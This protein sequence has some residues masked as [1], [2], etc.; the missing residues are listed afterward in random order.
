MKLNEIVSAKEHRI[1]ELLIQYGIVLASWDHETGEIL[2]PKGFTFHNSSHVKDIEILPDGTVN[3]DGYINL[4]GTK[5][6]KLPFKFGKISQGLTIA[7]NRKLATLVGCPT[8]VK[9]LDLSSC[10]SLT[11]LKGSPTTVH[12]SVSLFF[13]NNLESY[14]G[15]PTQ[16]DG[17]LIL[18]SCTKLKSLK[19]LPRTLGGSLV[20]SSIPNK[21]F[22]LEGMP[23]ELGT[24][25]EG[26]LQ[27]C[28]LKITSLTHLPKRINGVI[29]LSGSTNIRNMLALFKVRGVTEIQ[30]D[31]NKKLESI[32]N[33]YVESRDIME[34]Q[35]ELIDAGLEEYART[36]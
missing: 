16:V 3:I 18:T 28:N 14:D 25:E 4:S 8:E 30:I 27:L 2:P 11:S 34:C 21:E 7:E 13:C 32:L 9:A 1:R 22:S 31:H 23:E 6:A 17:N 12:G 19:G 36:K 20:V 35:E 24:H 5:F 15:G 10:Q 29:D 33:K 26:N